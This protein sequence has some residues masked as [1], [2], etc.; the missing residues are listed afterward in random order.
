[1]LCVARDNVCVV[2]GMIRVHPHEDV[3]ST[4]GESGTGS[5]SGT[6]TSVLHLHLQVSS[7]SEL[8]LLREAILRRIQQ[9]HK[10]LNGT[11]S[12]TSS[13][14]SEARSWQMANLFKLA[15]QVAP[16]HSLLMELQDS[17]KVRSRVG[18]NLFDNMIVPHACYVD[19]PEGSQWPP[20]RQSRSGNPAPEPGWA[21]H[22]SPPG[23]IPSDARV[24][25]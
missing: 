12:W 25:G 21:C 23:N 9:G 14:T 5:N 19:N 7:A 15:Q 13:I 18:E 22:D 1:M 10:N 17:M 11:I 3:P 20:G 24:D 2:Q 8:P 6:A 4:C 16:A